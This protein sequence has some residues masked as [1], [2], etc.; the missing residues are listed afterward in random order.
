MTEG[1]TLQNKAN[2]QIKQLIVEI[3]KSQKPETTQQLKLLQEKT[4]LPY[5]ELNKILIQLESEDIIYFTKKETSLPQTLQMYVLSS[6]AAWYWISIALSIV[7][8][9]TVFIIP[10]TSYPLEYVRITIGLLYV[11]FIPGY[12]FI[13]MVFP[14]NLPIKTNSVNMDMIERISL[15]AGMSLALLPVVGLILN[16]TPWGIRL[17]P[18]T[19]SLLVLTIVFATAAVIREYQTKP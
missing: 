8:A 1:S 6:K 4:N 10:A 13:K 5:E 19:V 3:I 2:D 15:S 9:L 14:S 11:L 16:F 7:T 18:I 12:V 17:I